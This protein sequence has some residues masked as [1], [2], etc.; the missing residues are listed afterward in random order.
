MWTLKEEDADPAKKKMRMKM[1]RIEQSTLA[2]PTWTLEEEEEEEDN[3][4]E[5]KVQWWCVSAVAVSVEQNWSS[6]QNLKINYWA[7][8]WM[9]ILWWMKP[10]DED[11]TKTDKFCASCL[12]KKKKYLLSMN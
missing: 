10:S 5:K 6:T 2:L 9:M 11:T 7:W 8:L 4:E 12:K 1:K 3:E